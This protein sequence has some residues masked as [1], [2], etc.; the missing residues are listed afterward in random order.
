MPA[1]PATTTRPEPTV[2]HASIWSAF[3]LL[4]DGIVVVDARGDIV[5]ANRRLL[6]LLGYEAGDLVGQPI[7]L[8]VPDAARARHAEDRARFLTDPVTRSMGTVPDLRARR[9]D[10]TEVAVDVSLSPTRLDG[11]TVVVAAVRDVT[12]RFVVETHEAKLEERERLARQLHDTVIQDV[13][14]TGLALASLA[15]QVPDLLRPQLDELIDRQD[16]TIQRLRSAI[17]ELEPSEA[18]QALSVLVDALVTESTPVLGFTPALT[19]EGPVDAA[20]DDEVAEQLLLALREALVNISLHARARS[21]YIDL[22]VADG[23]LELRVLDD[24][25]GVP[26]D[27]ARLGSGLANLRRRAGALGGVCEVQR[28]RPQGTLVRWTVPLGSVSAS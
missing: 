6:N 7:E 16:A 15:S 27:V 24:G 11:E 26:L 1:S 17:F 3:E 9:A 5:H 22:A 10:G 8:L 4:P 2:A 14:T 21:A 18:E 12:G 23:E 25:V 20:V 19:L 13:F 28:C